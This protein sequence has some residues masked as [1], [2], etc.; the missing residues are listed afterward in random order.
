MVSL[1]TTIDQAAD[2]QVKLLPPERLAEFTRNYRAAMTTD[3]PDDQTYTDK[4]I[5]ALVRRVEAGVPPHVDFAVWGKHG[6]RTERDLK[7]RVR[8]RDAYGHERLQEIPG[9]NCWEAW[10]SSWLVFK[11]AAI[12]ARIATC[13]TLD[14][15]A[16]KLKERARN[17]PGAWYLLFKADI[18]M[19]SEEWLK[20]KRRQEAT[21]SIAPILSNFDINMPWES[22][23]RHSAMD[24][25]YW[26][27]NIDLPAMRAEFRRETQYPTFQT[28]GAEDPGFH[29][30]QKRSWDQ[31]EGDDDWNGGGRKGGGKQK[32]KAKGKSDKGSKGDK[33]GKKDAPEKR[34]DGR[35]TK[36]VNGLQLC[37]SFNRI[38]GGCQASCTHNRA[39]AC[40]WC[41]QP[42]RAI[43]CPKH[44]N[45]VPPAPPKSG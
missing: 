13:A 39:H 7:F 4:Q 29:T 40:E 35:F 16:S 44:P 14:L 6:N 37:F 25:A 36:S 41:R 18:I 3:P 38:K 21:H 24:E 34:G 45:W 42:H 15:Y 43:D 8:V 10:E 27:K 19:R 20:E 30:G 17:Y 32:G 28:G 22:V 23:I 33:N 1:S 26:T 9:P 12:A 31:M 11:T 2:G 5:S